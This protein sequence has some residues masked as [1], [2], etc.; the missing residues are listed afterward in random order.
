MNAPT[1]R[2]LFARLSLHPSVSSS[3][4]SR[5]STLTASKSTLSSLS[6]NAVP[7]STRQLH[8]TGTQAAKGSSAP[9][10]FNDGGRKKKN[11]REKGPDPRIHN[12][13]IS[14]PRKVPAPLRFARN[15]ADRHWTIHRAW[16]LYQNKERMRRTLELE[17]MYNGMHNACEELRKTSGPGLRDEGYLYRIAL[18]KKGVYGHHSIPIEYAR[19]QTETPAREAWNH[20]W[21]R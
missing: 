16:L 21:K 6:R 17:R 1:V 15:R 3:A 18:E 7:S 20:D 8:V 12:L 11:I 14:M 19:H 2:N 10:S 13:K 5:T 9:N 4:I